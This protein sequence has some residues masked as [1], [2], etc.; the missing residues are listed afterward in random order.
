MLSATHIPGGN[1]VGLLNHRQLVFLCGLALLF[2]LQPAFQFPDALLHCQPGLF[3]RFLRGRFLIKTAQLL[4]YILVCS[5]GR[6]ESVVTT[7]VNASGGFRFLVILHCLGSRCGLSFGFI[8]TQGEGEILQRPHFF[9]L[10]T[11]HGFLRVSVDLVA[12]DTVLFGCGQFGI[13]T[14]LLLLFVL[15]GWGED[16]PHG[17]CE[18][19]EQQRENDHFLPLLYLLGRELF[20]LFLRRRLILFLCRIH[21]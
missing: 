16:E 18:Q 6:P 17:S 7:G 8:F 19:Q 13:E 4:V 5:D 15:P 3:V 2:F 21:N 12:H 1:G 9:L 14:F 11:L 20:F 10:F